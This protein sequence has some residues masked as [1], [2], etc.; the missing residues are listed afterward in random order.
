MHPMLLQIGFLKL[1]TYGLMIVIGFLCGLYLIY[2]EAK[3][4]GLNGDRVVDLSFLGLGFGLLGGRIVY[5]L[6]RLDYFSQH[7]IEIFYFWEGG[8]VFY[9]GFL[10]GA[11]A[12]WFFSKKYN[13]P[14]LKVM[15]M[16]TP[17]LAIAHFFG[18]LGCFSAGCC[19]GRPASKDLPWAV[20]FRD[21]LSLAPPGIPLHP[22]QLYDAL[23]A[24]IIF[25][26]LMFM[27]RREKFVG[28]LFVIYM[29]MY[30]IGRSIV[31]VFRGDTI[32]G[33]II[34]PYL[35]TSQFLSVFVFILGIVLWVIWK[36]K[37]PIQ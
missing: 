8:L 19:Y 9:G 3:R 6:T 34:E 18:R 17:S 2:N 10:G 27:R 24:L 30:S 36:K 13:L 15:D 25:S 4:Q 12:F 11:F 20:V 16:A 26:V 22:T 5:I 14:T 29:L 1:H 7:P 35:S 23:N 28:Q 33:F 37:Y 31:E 32:R 21:P